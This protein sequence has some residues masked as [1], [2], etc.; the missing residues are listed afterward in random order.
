MFDR[1]LIPDK[2]TLLRKAKTNMSA[3]VT[4]AINSLVFDAKIAQ[5]EAIK[6]F[7]SDKMNDAV[8]DLDSFCQL[9]DEFAS[10]TEKN[11]VKLKVTKVKG[12]KYDK[13]KRTRKPTF[14]NYWL[15][16]RLKT[17]AEEQK[18]VTEDE[19]VGKGSRMKLIAVEWKDFKESNNFDEARAEWSELSSSDEKFQKEKTAKKDKPKKKKPSKVVVEKEQSD[20]DDAELSKIEPINSDSEED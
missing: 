16:Q 13:S 9:L 2:Q 10:S 14:Y 20:S 11:T 8:C 15:G 6:V 17:F 12:D 18:S 1:P 3:K 5:I 19:K 7:L 4:N